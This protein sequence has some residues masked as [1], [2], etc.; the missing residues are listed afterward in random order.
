MEITIPF[1]S[2]YNMLDL[3]KL[4]SL[5]FDKV[6]I[7]CPM[8]DYDKPYFSMDIYNHMKI[9]MDENVVNVD[10]VPIFND[11]LSDKLT[12]FVMNLVIESLGSED[13]SEIFKLM[14]LE[15]IS[16]F[17]MTTRPDDDP[18]VEWAMEA[19]NNQFFQIEFQITKTFEL[20]C[21]GKNATSSY[22]TQPKIYN[23]ITSQYLN[24]HNGNI[25]IE[26]LSI[27]L[28]NY[29]NLSFEDILDVRYHAKDQLLEMRAYI[30]ELSKYNDFENFT[31]LQ[32]Y[33]KRKINK[34]I[35]EFNTKITES[36]ISF[37][38]SVLHELKNPISYT[39]L[40]ATFFGDISKQIALAVSMG[41][42]TADASLEYFK[43][44]KKMK[45]E[46]L[47]FRFNIK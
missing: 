9:L 7:L 30:Y 45:N 1:E 19:A 41:L 32:A 12:D 22:I 8:F 28:P 16:E 10:F 26:A 24:K 29:K 39:P 38:Q 17:L 23:K 47:F 11:S 44:R 2:T 15:W 14:N 46:P 5:Y 42:I 33:I 27:L 25:A 35:R 18:F 3:I 34:S 40:L 6:N 13:T 37:F 20:L 21:S 4:A 43:R 36:K 31:D